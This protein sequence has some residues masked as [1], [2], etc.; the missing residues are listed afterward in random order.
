ML[1]EQA[2]LSSVANN[3]KTILVFMTRPPYRLGVVLIQ[4]YLLCNINYLYKTIQILYQTSIWL[5]KLQAEQ[6]IIPSGTMI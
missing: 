3:G 5:K 4:I 1:E 2:L 6:K